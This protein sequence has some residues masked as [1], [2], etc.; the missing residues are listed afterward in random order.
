MIIY[1]VKGIAC[2][3][4][5]WALH[6]FSLEKER[7]HGFNRFY[8]L[9]APVISVLI[10]FVPLRPGDAGTGTAWLPLETVTA[11][12]KEMDL[13]AVETIVESGDTFA[14]AML[15]WGVPAV[16]LL[17]VIFLLIRFAVN[18][19]R[20]RRAIRASDRYQVPGATMVAM[21][22]STEVCTFM[23]YIFCSRDEYRAGAIPAA[24]L[25]HELAHVKQRHTWD[26]LFMEVFG[27]L[28][29]FNP[30]M[31]LYKRSVRLNHEFLA[32]E[33]VMDHPGK[34]AGYQRLLLDRLAGGVAPSLVS[35][36]NYSQTKKRLIMMTQKQNPQRVW[37]KGACL[38]LFAGGL[39]YFASDEARAQEAPPYPGVIEW[40]Y[41]QVISPKSP[42]PPPPMDLD[43]L[44]VA[45]P[46]R[47][48]MEGL[49]T[50][51]GATPEELADY[52][53]TFEAHRIEKTDADGSPRNPEFDLSNAEKERLLKIREKMSREQLEQQ[54]YAIFRR[55]APYKNP[56]SPE[57]FESFKKADVYGVWL[58]NKKVESAALSAYTNSDIADYS[59]SKLYG[60]AKEGRS[61]THQLN[62][63]TN[64]YFDANY[65]R[66]A[67]D[68][69]IITEGARREPK[70]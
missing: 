37:L 50:G 34:V 64:Q 13:S 35:S 55:P 39:F 53:A 51:A 57:L 43:E 5:L 61:Y 21:P 66:R 23:G 8:L 48:P 18:I 52:D 56:P 1:L 17:G 32:D 12:E 15:S 63:E 29:W 24:V 45:P 28:Y 38:S 7:M 36:F 46:P 58:D 42:P 31:A 2:S 10:P 40:K 25:Q 65:K 6:R 59:I 33:Q 47:P 22:G 54:T 16:Y 19:A 62:L 67:A 4:I 69:F 20:I 14:G 68:L 70:K 27:A 9:L 11:A 26:I 3:F 49:V 41:T 60:S 44:P 30:V